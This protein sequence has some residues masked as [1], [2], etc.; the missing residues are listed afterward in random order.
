MVRCPPHLYF[1]SQNFS[2]RIYLAFRSRD[3]DCNDDITFSSLLGP[4]KELKE[5][6]KQNVSTRKNSINND[7]RKSF[8]SSSFISRAERDGSGVGKAYSIVAFCLGYL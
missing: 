3:I 4:D 1:R 2:D 8:T 6:T 7:D 5:F